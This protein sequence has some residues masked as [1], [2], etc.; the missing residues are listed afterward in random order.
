MIVQVDSVN[1][2]CVAVYLDA[3]YA[4]FEDSHLEKR[5]RASLWF[6]WRKREPKHKKMSDLQ[7]IVIFF[8]LVTS[9]VM[10]VNSFVRR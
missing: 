1:G 10:P 3:T 8:H 6:P 5:V 2:P 4:L 7:E 9:G